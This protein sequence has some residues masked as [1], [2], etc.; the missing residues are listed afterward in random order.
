MKIIQ[1]GTVLVECPAN[2]KDWII[3][4]LEVDPA[5]LTLFYSDAE[6]REMAR[7]KI[8]R[9]YPT[10]KQLNILRAGTD[11]EKTQMGTFIDAVRA[12][13]NGESPVPAELEAIQP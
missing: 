2:Q 8:E 1:N 4:G 3:A 11:E 13:S 9:H 12:W 10:Y 5:T 6:I 7:I